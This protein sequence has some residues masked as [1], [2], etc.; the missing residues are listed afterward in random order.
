MKRWEASLRRPP[1]DLTDPEEIE[2]D[3]AIRRNIQNVFGITIEDD[4][5]LTVRLPNNGQELTP[6]QQAVIAAE[7]RL[8]RDLRAAGLI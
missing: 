6:S 1:A 8:T 7:A 3:Q 4:D 5:T 2:R